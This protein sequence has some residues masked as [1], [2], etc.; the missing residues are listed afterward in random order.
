LWNDVTGFDPHVGDGLTGNVAFV[1]TIA[2][3]F[4]SI[5][6][7]EFDDKT[8]YNSS[9]FVVYA[10]LLPTEFSNAVATLSFTSSKTPSHNTR[11]GKATVFSTLEGL[12]TQ[13]T[14]DGERMETANQHLVWGD[15]FW[16]TEEEDENN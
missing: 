7:P 11:P 15:C 9:P 12:L 10:G 1:N 6:N 16:P 13:D 5:N 14:T 4:L 3:R 2:P 8:K